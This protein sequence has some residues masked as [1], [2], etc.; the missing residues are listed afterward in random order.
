MYKSFFVKMTFIV[1]TCY[2]KT[3]KMTLK[4]SFKS[5]CMEEKGKENNFWL[6]LAWDLDTIWVPQNHVK[7]DKI[8]MLK[9]DLKK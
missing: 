3:F 8:E 7:G 2:K 1:S 4:Q 5:W 6:V 9:T